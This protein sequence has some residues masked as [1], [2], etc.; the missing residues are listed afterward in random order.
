M[1]E[2]GE[3][4]CVGLLKPF[5]FYPST[6]GQTLGCVSPRAVLTPGLYFG[7]PRKA[8]PWAGAGEDPQI[9]S[10]SITSFSA[11]AFH[12]AMLY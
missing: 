5:D 3:S 12:R 7:V 10:L 4:P 8:S 1:P 11:A 9:R 2:T 6:A